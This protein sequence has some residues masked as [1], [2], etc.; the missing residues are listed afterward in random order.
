[1]VDRGDK[2]ERV[3]I[4][5]Q[6]GSRQGKV[7][8]LDPKMVSTLGVCNAGVCGG[9]PVRNAVYIQVAQCRAVWRILGGLL[10]VLEKFEFVKGDWCLV[11]C[12]CC[13]RGVDSSSDQEVG[14]AVESRKLPNKTVC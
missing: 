13:C 11:R 2:V 8:S 1:M 10:D 7:V 5:V 12:R 9:S 3:S 4:R 6:V 14:N